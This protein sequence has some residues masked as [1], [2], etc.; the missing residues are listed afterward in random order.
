MNEGRRWPAGWGRLHGQRLALAVEFGQDRCA[1]PALVTSTSQLARCRHAQPRFSAYSVSTFLLAPFARPSPGI[2]GSNVPH[3]DAVRKAEPQGRPL[4]GIMCITVTWTL[5]SRPLA[6]PSTRERPR[7]DV[8]C[9]GWACDWI[10]CRLF[11]FSPH[12]QTK[13]KDQGYTESASARARKSFAPSPRHALPCMHASV[14]GLV[15]ASF[16]SMTRAFFV[17]EK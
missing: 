8:Q 17:W 5:A 12:G 3:L 11:L 13:D 9:G 1:R 10:G 7:S 2:L 16:S 14:V 4:V 6:I 15:D